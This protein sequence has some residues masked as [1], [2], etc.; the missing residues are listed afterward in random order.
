MASRLLS[1]HVNKLI[2]IEIIIIIIG[3]PS[4]LLILFGNN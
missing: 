4:V 3:T 2:E 1:L